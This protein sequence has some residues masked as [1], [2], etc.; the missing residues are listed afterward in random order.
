MKGI[1][2]PTIYIAIYNVHNAR[3][4]MH[5][6]SRINYQLEWEFLESKEQG[7]HLL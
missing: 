5:T 4:L 2:I 3:V 6:D 7:T 1:T